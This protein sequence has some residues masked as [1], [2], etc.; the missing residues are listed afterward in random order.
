ML[1]GKFDH[2]GVDLDLRQALDRLVLEHFLGDAAIAAAHDQHFPGVAMRQDRHMRHHL[3]VDELVLRGDLGGAV[4]HQDFAEMLLLEQDQMVVA[5]LLLVEHPFDLEGHA[6]AKI[7]EQRFRDPAFCGHG[8]PSS[9]C[10]LRRLTRLA[11]R[12]HVREADYP[13]KKTKGGRNLWLR[14]HPLIG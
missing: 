6:E 10:Q 7:V 1:L 5:G 14:P 12:I 13:R 4:Q 3:V 2:R 9:A 11:G 8:S